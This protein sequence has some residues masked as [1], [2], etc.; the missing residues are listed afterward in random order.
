[1]NIVFFNHFHNG[2]I[3]V[4]R[5]FIRK[6]MEKVWER[7]R[8]VSFTYAHRNSGELLADI[9]RLGYGG[10]QGVGSE[11]SGCYINGE[12]VYINTWYAQQQ[13]KY[14][15]RYGISIDCLY[16]ALDD[17]CKMMLGFSLSDISDDPKVFFPTIDYSK[18]QIG[19]AVKWLN[20]NADAKKVFISNGKVL[21]GQAHE[22]DMTGIII[23]VAEKHRDKTFIVSNREGHI[24][25]PNVVFS[26]DIIKKAGNDL[27]ENAYLSE[28]CDVIVGRASGTFSFAMTQRNLFERNV[29]FLCFSNLEP[30]KEGKFWLG[31]MLVDRVCYGA[32]VIVSNGG[33]EEMFAIINN[34][35]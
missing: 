32:N 33:L 25:L 29:K 6:I 16:A 7:D 12:T 26:S 3:H 22:F 4:S 8:N 27:N 20:A 24:D 18:F 21:S 17:S 11:H 23:R 9:D 34:N 13:F 10:W 30:K 35:V 19:E 2:D 14:M 15:N 1:M 5:G 31:D 28:S